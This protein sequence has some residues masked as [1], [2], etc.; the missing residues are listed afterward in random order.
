MNGS[1]DRPASASSL[2]RA[3][4]AALLRRVGAGDRAALT[5][6]Y[7]R[8]SAKLYGICLRLL[9][10]EAEAQEALQDSYLTIWRRAAQF[11]EARA[12]PITWLALIAH[13]RAVD[14]RRKRM[15]TSDELGAAGEIA[16]DRPD[17][18]ALLGE[19]EEQ[20][21]L[22]HCLERLEREAR[23][24][25]RAAFLDGHSYGELAARAGVPLGTMKS[26]MRRGL[27]Q[28]R[29]CMEG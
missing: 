19:A 1:M 23:T 28:L 21:L 25:I 5:A 16:D 17:A 13:S 3:E 8:T 24:M 29:G 14:L 11:D 20:D 7:E 4:L 12:S 26:R 2:A 15:V 18:L 10:C 6:V 22:H 9:G 27:Q